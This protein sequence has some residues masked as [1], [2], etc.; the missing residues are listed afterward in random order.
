MINI[1]LPKPS[2]SIILSDYN[3][4]KNGPGFYFM[5]NKKGEIIYIGESKNIRR[6]LSRHFRGKS[7]ATR[8]FFHLFYSVD[9]FYCLPNERKIYEV[10]AINYYNPLGNIWDNCNMSQLELKV[11]RTDWIKGE[12]EGAG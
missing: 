10:F 7:D 11:R 2:T 9:I 3:K 1:E 12:Q 8:L 5:K 4:T 6:R